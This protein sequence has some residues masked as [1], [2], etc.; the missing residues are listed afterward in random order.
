MTAQIFFATRSAARVAGFG[1][2]TNNGSTAPKRWARSVDVV[3][4]GNKTL[5]V[6]R[7]VRN[8]GHKAVTIIT[9]KT[10]TLVH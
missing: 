2:M 7:G 9:K 4:T 1:K 6:G 3:S 10:K 5:S 8:N